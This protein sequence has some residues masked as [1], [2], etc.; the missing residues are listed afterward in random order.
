M[1]II[2]QDLPNSCNTCPCVNDDDSG[3]YCNLD[4]EIETSC[5]ERPDKCPMIHIPYSMHTLK[6]AYDTGYKDGWT[7]GYEHGNEDLYEVINNR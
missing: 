7:S 3:Q 2:E 6:E 5:K 4:P 1:L